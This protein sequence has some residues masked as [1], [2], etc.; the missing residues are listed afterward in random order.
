MF[1][2]KHTAKVYSNLILYVY[3]EWSPPT[4][5]KSNVDSGFRFQTCNMIGFISGLKEYKEGVLRAH[6][7]YRKIHNAKPL[8]LSQGLS[9]GAMR[10]ARK[11]AKRIKAIRHSKWFN[12]NKVWENLLMSAVP[13][14]G[15]FVAKIW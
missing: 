1:P 14:R 3:F 7:K 12:K 15:D 13:L 10:Y 5:L 9:R 11:L 2:P 6:N 4:S 8:R